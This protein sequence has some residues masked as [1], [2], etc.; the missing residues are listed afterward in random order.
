MK[1]ILFVLWLC[2]A[3]SL[4]SNVGMNAAEPALTLNVWPDQAPG[5][6]GALAA[7]KTEFFKGPLPK[8]QVSNVSKPMLEVFRPAK[9]QANGTAVVICPGGGFNVLMMDYEGEDCA[10]W[11]NTLGVTTIV[12]KYRVPVRPGGPRYLAALQ[13]TQR[14]LSLVRSKAAE[15]GLDPKRIGILGFSAGGEAAALLATGHDKLSYPAV[16]AVDQVNSR[17]DFFLAVYPGGL[18]ENGSLLADVHVTKDTPPTFI[19]VANNDPA[20]EGSVLLYQ[21]L[22]KAG[23]SAELHIYADGVHGFG[24]RP[25]PEPHATWTARLADWLKQQGL[26][27]PAN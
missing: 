2:A 7:E 4:L 20:S 6:K 12:L 21:A 8:K 27:K 13:D 24:M 22:K 18:A 15:W 16:D 1:K 25:S 9:G 10:T 3:G 5:E 11:L 19:T 26:L 17:P 23:V 14:A